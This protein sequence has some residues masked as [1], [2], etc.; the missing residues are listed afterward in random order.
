MVYWTKAAMFVF[1]EL[2]LSMPR[3]V[4]PCWSPLRLFAFHLP[5]PNCLSSSFLDIFPENTPLSTWSSG[6][7]YASF[8]KSDGSDLC[9]VASFHASAFSS[10]KSEI[11]DYSATGVVSGKI[12][13]A[14]TK[15]AT[16]KPLVKRKG[17][18]QSGHLK[19]MVS[20][21]S[22]PNLMVPADILTDWFIIPHFCVQRFAFSANLWN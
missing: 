22:S 2:A 13:E 10:F 3:I 17:C 4:S 7:L 8:S 11:K 18:C 15:P 16:L 20:V 6:V 9:A 19:S 21:V 1:E 12:F 5:F 14:P